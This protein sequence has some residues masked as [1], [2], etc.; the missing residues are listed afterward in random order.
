MTD[1]LGKRLDLNLT[2]QRLQGI[3]QRLQSRLDKTPEY[4]D[5]AD[6]YAPERYGVF[7]SYAR[8]NTSA[9]T[10]LNALLNF[11][12]TVVRGALKAGQA[13]A[14]FRDAAPDKAGDAIEDLAEFGQKLTE[15]FN[16]PLS[17]LHGGDKS[18]P[19]ATLLF[20]EAARALRPSLTADPAAA[21]NAMLELIVLRND[22]PFKAKLADYLAGKLPTKDDT[23]VEQR[24]VSLK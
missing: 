1:F 9:I 5:L 22:S 4:K 15:T 2:G 3:L 12:S 10:N 14:R 6:D 23:L 19:L 11:E 8:N 20:I 13:M 7:L 24:I 21:A 18:Q 17:G 16:K